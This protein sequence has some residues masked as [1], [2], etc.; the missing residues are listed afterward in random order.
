MEQKPYN[1]MEALDER[2]YEFDYNFKINGTIFEVSVN[3]YDG[4]MNINKDTDTDLTDE[5]S[6][7][8]NKLHRRNMQIKDLKEQLSLA[9]K[10]SNLLY[11]QKSERT[12]EIRK[13]ERVISELRLK[14][15]GQLKEFSS[16]VFEWLLTNR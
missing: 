3:N 14:N 6:Q 7:L 8:K 11:Q 2:G 1:K 4:L 9:D 10:H 13:L 16:D 15:T 5:Y 12:F